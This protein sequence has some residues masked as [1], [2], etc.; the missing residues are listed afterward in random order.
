M[1]F[2]WAPWRMSYILDKKDEGCLFC[3]N[4]TEKRDRENLILHHGKYGFVM[5]NKFPYNN[6]HLMVV[7]NRHSLD[8]EAL[9][10]NEI[11]ELFHLL[12]MATRVLKDLLHPHGFNIGINIG[13]VGG[14]GEDHLH[15]HIVPRWAG[16][17]NFMPILSETKIIPQYLEKTYQLL[18]PGFRNYLR[19]R[20]VRKEVKRP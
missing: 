17:T 6:G 10:E 16:D 9:H 14:A 3:R 18:R 2:L 7:P 20:I 11:K 8:F 12:R 13:R 15:V 4:A 19:K 5:M 1:K